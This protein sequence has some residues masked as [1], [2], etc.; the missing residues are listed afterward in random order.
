MILGQVC[1]G[2]TSEMSLKKS[3]LL[4]CKFADGED[5]NLTWPGG[6]T[7][8]NLVKY[9]E[10]SIR[11]RG[12]F[13]LDELLEIEVSYL[14]EDG[15]VSWKATTLEE[16]A[17]D[18]RINIVRVVKQGDP[19]KTMITESASKIKGLNESKRSSINQ[20]IYMESMRSQENSNSKQY[21]SVTREELK[22]HN[23]QEDCWISYRGKVYDITKYLQF[24]PGG[25]FP[26]F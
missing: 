10:N 11:K 5:F 19:R 2:K 22:I 3:G 12:S 20:A 16:L 21:K 9:M 24:H 14:E 26:Q 1:S 25:R 13:S 15:H 17:E 6:Q 7:K 8:Q 4:V 23:K 18:C